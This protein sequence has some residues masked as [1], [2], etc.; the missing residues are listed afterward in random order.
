MNLA[1]AT[2]V[3]AS[4]DNGDKLRL[5]ANLAYNLTI[6]ARDA[7]DETGLADADKLRSLNELQH[8][9]LG[10][11]RSL[12]GGSSDRHLPDEVLAAMFFAERDDASLSR[13]LAHAFERAADAACRADREV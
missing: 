6:I 3:L 5:L 12:I 4:L 9:V 8:R 2:N 1:S 10:E 13:L 7:Y 11:L